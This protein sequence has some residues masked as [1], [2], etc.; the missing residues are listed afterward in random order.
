[1][2]RTVSLALPPEPESVRQA[3]TWV[4]AC[5]GAWLIPAG[6]ADDAVL[7][8]SE[9]V[10]NAVLHG[11]S[12]LEL[13]LQLGRGVLR[14]EVYDED[15]RLPSPTVPNADALGGRGLQIVAGMSRSWGADPV[16]GGKL[17]WCEVS[18]LPATA[19]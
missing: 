16:P 13:R 15:A 5:C 19:R 12:P 3:R 7:L 10:G 4:R 11:R 2:D 14:I 9:L 1:M 8:A 17:V 6:V 18:L